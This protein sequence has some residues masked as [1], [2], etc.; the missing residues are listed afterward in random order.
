MAHQIISG[1]A[2]GKPKVIDYVAKNDLPYVITS[3][4]LGNIY[5]F[6]QAS[7]GKY[8]QT[9][10]KKYLLLQSFWGEFTPLSRFSGDTELSRVIIDNK[11]IIHIIY[12]RRTDKQF[13][14]VYQQK[15][16]DKNIWLDEVVIHGSAQPFPESSILWINE[17][18]IVFWVR[19]DTLYYSSTSDGGNTWSKPSKYNFPVGRQ[20]FC[21]GYK[22]NSLH[23][24]D[25]IFATDIP[26]S[27]INGFKLA[28]YEEPA[29]KS[30]N[31][32][33][34]E[35]KNMIVDSLKL[36]N[37]NIE[38]LKESNT[39]IRQNLTQLSLSQQSFE[40]ELTKYS[41]RLNFF[42]NEINQ[43]RNMNKQLESYREALIELRNKFED[44]I[45]KESNPT[46]L[47]TLLDRPDP[48][49]NL[50]AN[51]STGL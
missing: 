26:G 2:A 6:Y 31:L 17:S 13:E 4:K 42:E 39:E 1:G 29:G 9:G 30:G 10:Y 33:P 46:N 28:F 11:N 43:V 36:I 16:P 25:K 37:A 15:V 22:S 23:E 45:T 41:V 48:D 19:N 40:R 5:A 49:N 18:I 24:S 27:F 12:Q 32:S 3:D 51:V 50:P 20:I 14:L 47:D 34:D 35:L 8:M 38:E 7:D 21:F 44:S